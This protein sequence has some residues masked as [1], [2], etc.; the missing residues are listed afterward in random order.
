MLTVVTLS[1]LAVGIYAV[2]VWSDAMNEIER[3]GM[4]PGDLASPIK[5]ET[6]ASHLDPRT[7]HEKLVA[8]VIN[9]R[10]GV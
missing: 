10:M 8:T 1:A 2:T 3:D 9:K 6:T 4:E 5:V 7:V